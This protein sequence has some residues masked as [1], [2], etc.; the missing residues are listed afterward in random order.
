MQKELAREG[1]GSSRRRKSAPSGTKRKLDVE[2]EDEIEVESVTDGETT[3]TGRTL[4]DAFSEIG[5]SLS[6]SIGDKNTFDLFTF[7]EPKKD[8]GDHPRM[9]A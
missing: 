2:E 1:A 3:E 7:D 4:G 5:T 6:N 8:W 9:G